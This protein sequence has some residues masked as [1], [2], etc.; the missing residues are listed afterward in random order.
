MNEGIFKASGF[1]WANVSWIYEKG[2]FEEAVC[3]KISKA[4][5]TEHDSQVARFFTHRLRYV[6]RHSFNWQFFQVASWMY[7]IPRSAI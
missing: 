1:F 7:D 5:D 6:E 4:Q 2:D 3:K